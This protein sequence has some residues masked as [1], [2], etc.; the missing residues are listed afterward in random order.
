MRIERMV[1]LAVM[2]D[3]PFLLVSITSADLAYSIATK[4]TP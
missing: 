2:S 1:V 3:F 4:L